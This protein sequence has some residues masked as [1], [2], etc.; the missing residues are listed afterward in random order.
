MIQLHIYCDVYVS[1]LT[2]LLPSR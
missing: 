1:M 2:G